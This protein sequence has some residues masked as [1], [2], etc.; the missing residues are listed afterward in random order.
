MALK[1]RLFA[2]F[3]LLVLVLLLVPAAFAQDA[4]PP[5]KLALSTTYPGQIIGLGESVTYQ[6]TLSS[7]TP[8]TV[9]LS[10]TKIPDGWTATFRGGT[11]II[12]SAYVDP[13]AT[14]SVELRLDPPADVAPG[15]YQFEVQAA[16]SDQTTRFPLAL[17]I[18]DK[19]PPRL[20]F[21]TDLPTI[22]GSPTTT[23]R[24]TASLQNQGAEDLTI[25]LVGNTPDVFQLNYTLSGQD[26]TSF[27]LAANETKSI[28]IEAKPV[29]N[30]PAGQYPLDIL[31]QSS[32]VSADLKLSA[33]VTGQ[34]DLSVSSPDG[35]LSAQ[36]TAGK[37]SPVQVT[38]SN[39]GSASAQ[40]IQLSSTNPS[41][42]T[43]TFDPATVSELPAGQQVNV[44]AN[45]LP[46][47][48]AVAGDYV[49]TVKAQPADGATQTADF[50]ITVTTSTLWG[51]IGVVLIAAAVVVVG[52]AVA[53]FG[54]R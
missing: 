20:T 8:E 5:A 1:S 22:K 53:R 36:A 34:S 46:A 3:S 17:T 14:T 25:N 33:E 4:A 31:A 49:V 6:L 9:Q 16:G 38:L 41:G 54:R 28:S 7:S 47:D 48:K 10:M 50:R 19:L 52:L 51:I 26:V 37:Q 15:D 32:E 43:V 24:Y 45:I 44:T 23:F 11:R 29:G 40:D 21:T 42:W 27:P 18:K 13:A 2:G 35:R 39:N 30:V 12:D